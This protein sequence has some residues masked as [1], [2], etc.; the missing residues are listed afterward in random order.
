MHTTNKTQQNTNIHI[1]IHRP[2]RSS[3]HASNAHARTRHELRAGLQEEVVRVGQNDLRACVPQL[4][5]RQAL[6]RGLMFGFCFG[7]R[8]MGGKHIYIV[9]VVILFADGRMYKIHTYTQTYDQTHARKHMHAPTHT[10][11]RM[12]KH[13]HTHLGAAEDEGGRH[14]LPMRRL[15]L[16]TARGAALGVALYLF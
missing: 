3:F 15:Q 14:H 13:M 8:W 2:S 9:C 7:G 6:H 1:H 4:L 11:T 12:T 10:H 16:P 5:R